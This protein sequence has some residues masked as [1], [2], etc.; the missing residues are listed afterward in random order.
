MKTDLREVRTRHALQQSLMSLVLESGY[1]PITVSD[2]ASRAG[3]ARKTFYAHYPDKDALLID[4]ITPQLTTL[5]QS[6]SNTDVNSLLVDNKPASYSAFKYVQE[7][8]AFFRAMLS[9]HGSAGF[10]SY[11]LKIMTQSSYQMH[12][13]IWQTVP[14]P[15]VDPQLIAHFLAGALLNCIIWWLNHDCNPSAESMAYT[16]SRLAAPG[17]IDVLGLD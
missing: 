9:D 8:A 10:Y 15:S 12:Q 16:F 1:E 7:N 3:V 13:A 17:T 14:N 4:C 2:I 11:I 6:I 5:L